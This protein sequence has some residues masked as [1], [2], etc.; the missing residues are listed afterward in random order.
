[1]NSDI[2]KSLADALMGSS[3]YG[4]NK[5]A[6]NRKYYVCI[7]D[8][9]GGIRKQQATN[10]FQAELT[11]RDWCLNGWRAWVQDDK[12]TPISFATKPKEIN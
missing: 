5:A 10:I 4:T 1:M 8:G 9:H 3:S 11:M 2:L 6:D 7:S 12:G